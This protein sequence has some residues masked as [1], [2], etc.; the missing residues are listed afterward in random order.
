MNLKVKN[1]L[2]SVSNKKNLI[3]LNISRVW[4]GTGECAELRAQTRVM[5]ADWAAN[6]RTNLHKNITC[7]QVSE[8]QAHDIADTLNNIN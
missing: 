5:I 3:L 7:D 2:I 1:A 4:A 6:N 8:D